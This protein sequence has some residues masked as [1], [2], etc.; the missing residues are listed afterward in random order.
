M[1]IAVLLILLPLHAN[2][3]KFSFEFT[4]TVQVG[5]QIES[6][7]YSCT[8]KSEEEALTFLNNLQSSDKAIQ[9]IIKSAQYNIQQGTQGGR[10][11]L[12]RNIR[13]KQQDILA[14]SPLSMSQADFIKYFNFHS[15]R[16]SSKLP[17]MIGTTGATLTLITYMYTYHPEKVQSGFNYC[18]N[19]AQNWW[20]KI[21]GK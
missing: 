6:R 21:F 8:A 14:Q 2:E 3:Q 18:S 11:T 5:T 17:W 13:I 15:T 12:A 16:S 7:T 19:T 4:G 1:I 20:S 9:T 10:W